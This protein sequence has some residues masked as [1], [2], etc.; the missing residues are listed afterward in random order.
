MA[1]ATATAPTK[2][3]HKEVKPVAQPM[4]RA[5]ER[6]FFLTRMRDDFDRLVKSFADSWPGLWDFSDNNWRWGLDLQQ[7]DDALVVTAEAPGFEVGDFDIQVEDHRLVMRANRK[8]ETKE[9]DGQRTEER[10]SY[11]SITLPCDVV[12]DK[13]EAKYRNGILTVT[14]PKTPESKGRKITV[15]GG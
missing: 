15:Q 10:S 6:P 3:E 14:M 1:T 11:Q 7:K 2:Q 8:S 9:K 13:V 12:K 5:N 4:S